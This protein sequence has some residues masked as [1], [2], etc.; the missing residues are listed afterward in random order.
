MRTEEKICVLNLPAVSKASGTLEKLRKVDFDATS[1]TSTTSVVSSLSTDTNSTEECHGR[2]SRDQRQRLKKLSVRSEISQLKEIPT[3]ILEKKPVAFV[4]VDPWSTGN[5]LCHEIKKRGHEVILLWEEGNIRSETLP[6]SDVFFHRELSE[7]VRYVE[8]IL[9]MEYDIKAVIP[10]SETGVLL[11]EKLAN[12]L[13]FPSNPPRLAEARRNKYL[14]GETLRAN[15]VRA[16]KQ[17]ITTDLNEARAFVQELNPTPFRIIIKPNMGAGSDDVHLC[18][19]MEEVEEKFNLVNGKQ[20][21][22]GLKND[23]VLVQEFLSGTEYVID[24]VSRNGVHKIVSLWVY[25]KREVNNRFNVY[26]GSYPLVNDS[27]L[28]QQ[29]IDYVVQVLDALEFV[30][31]PAHAEIKMTP[32]GPCLVEIG[33]RCHGGGGTWLDMAQSCWR[34]DQLT[35]LIDTLALPEIVGEESKNDFE[36]HA[37][38][39][40]KFSGFGVIVDF[41]Q[42]ED[43]E[44]AEIVGDEIIKKLPSFSSVYYYYKEGDKLVKTVDC[45]T[46]P[47]Q[48]ILIHENEEQVRNDFD[49]VHTLLRQKDGF[50]KLKRD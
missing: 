32:T 12:A 6:A 20:N 29:L 30:N 42:Y 2:E 9:F 22:L 43:G 18:K 26:F 3:T 47:G 44:L 24:T 39:P 23:G 37:P 16:V 7:T 34:V 4:V 33:A 28:S 41:V 48:M 27:Q 10:G 13:S 35:T 45:N 31:G 14:M 21:S 25:D 1:Q 49:F 19:S 5:R 17:T 46:T 11:A 15:G 36:F 8:E 38:F 40:S 50:F